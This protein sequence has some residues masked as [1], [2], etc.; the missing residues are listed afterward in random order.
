MSERADWDK[1]GAMNDSPRLLALA[2]ALV[3]AWAAPAGAKNE[4]VLRKPAELPGLGLKLK[5]L[6]ESR[7]A[8]LPP[9]NAWT[10]TYGNGRQEEVYLPRDLW[11]AEQF[12]GRWRDERG[13]SLTLAQIRRPF[14][15][16]LSP[17]ERVTRAEYEAGAAATAAP[18]WTP[19]AL[20]AWA[21]VF[22]DAKAARLEPLRKTFYRV[23]QIIGFA[24]EGQ[25]PTRL[26]YAFRVSPPSGAPAGGPARWCFAMLD[27]AADAD[28]NK[29]AA[30]LLQDFFPSIEPLRGAAAAAAEVGPSRKYQKTTVQPAERSPEY[31]ASREQVVNSIRN[32]K[33]W[34]F[35]ETEHY[36]IL[37]NLKGMTG[38]VKD[39]QAHI[40]VLRRGYEKLIP[41]R[42]PITAVS[43]IRV[44]GSPEE[45]T[46]YVPADSS[47]S[48]GIWM[49]GR[50]EL[51]IKPVDWE[52]GAA[53]ENTLSIMAH[54]AFH[55]YLE[56]A[57][58]RIAPAT[59]FNEGHADFFG[60]AR[61][62]GRRLRIEEHPN[63]APL[64]ERLAAAGELDFRTVLR[65]TQE[66]FY[67]GG[68][69]VRS[70]NYAVAWALVYYL[71]KQAAFESASPY[72]GI[73]E[74]YVDALWRE[75]DRDK[76]T[77]AA[78]EGV[79]Q[80]ALQRDFTKFWRSP[81]QR[82]GARRNETPAEGRL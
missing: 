67:G 22:A 25:P 39:L 75:K 71:R 50:K 28:R 48:S 78:F 3:L 36:L 69:A 65:L 23:P 14:P 58:G 56:Y 16:K 35:V 12:A 19:E 20:A 32:A 42:A 33:N 74:R 73:L 76:A 34:W 40:E 5:L 2:A 24:L 49:P 29:V 59:W 26:C 44:F 45:Y 82:S 11:V 15:E 66:Q 37:S 1:V 18:D 21:A 68:D 55:Q 10:R 8:P 46:A 79:D 7:E 61:V 60:G 72:A 70:R 31:L 57:L 77:T 64:V 80:A 52:A 54:E 81:G 27:T 47:W 30:T 53:R 6:S 51:A 4:P 43:V 38:M 9:P 41:P 13:N 63:R 62:E 17:E